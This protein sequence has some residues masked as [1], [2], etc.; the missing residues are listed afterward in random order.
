MARIRLVDGEDLQHR[1]VVF[2]QEGLD[3]AGV[4]SLRR[5][6]DGVEAVG[7]RVERRGRVQVRRREA[8]LELGH[9]DDLAA[10]RLRQ[11]EDLLVADEAP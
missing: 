11:R 4:Q 6:G 2:A 3:A 7:L 10:V 1:R 5:R 8:A 9:L